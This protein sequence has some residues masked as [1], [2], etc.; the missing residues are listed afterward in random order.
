MKFHLASHFGLYLKNEL[1]FSKKLF[2][3]FIDLGLHSDLRENE[4]FVAKA[5][6]F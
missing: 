1:K 3:S 6:F 5:G 2:H 4:S